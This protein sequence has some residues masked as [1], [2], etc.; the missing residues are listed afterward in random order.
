MLK[1]KE[2]VDKNAVIAAETQ[3]KEAWIEAV[4]ELHALGVPT[5]AQAAELDWLIMQIKYS[6]KEIS[7][8]QEKCTAVGR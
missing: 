3:A 7:K 2:H 5:E 8:M 6:E 1:P 4:A